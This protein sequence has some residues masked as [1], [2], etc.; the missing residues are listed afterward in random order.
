M[1]TKSLKEHYGYLFEEENKKKTILFTNNF[2]I[3]SDED[4]V[5]IILAFDVLNS[6]LNNDNKTMLQHAFQGDK[7][8]GN[9][10]IN[11]NTGREIKFDKLSSPSGLNLDNPVKFANNEK[12]EVNSTN[13]IKNFT[14]LANQAIENFKSKGFTSIVLEQNNKKKIKRA[15]FN[16]AANRFF[17]DKLKSIINHKNQKINLNNLVDYFRKN[18]DNF[19]KPTV[20]KEQG[21]K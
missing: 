20:K 8:K 4:A 15:Q 7:V 14:I 17:D 12:D 11:I 16:L 19:Y 1:A 18:I 9:T 6:F 3:A 10:G 21:E 2:S 5:S 13:N